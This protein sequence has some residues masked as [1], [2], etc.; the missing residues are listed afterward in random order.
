MQVAAALHVIT[1]HLHNG[2]PFDVLQD[3]LDALERAN[4]NARRAAGADQTLL[5]LKAA[6]PACDS[7][8]LVADCTS[9]D[10]NEW[11]I[12]CRN[13]LCE[14]KG[15]GCPCGSAVRYPGK[16]HRWAAGL[17]QWHDLAAKLGVTYPHL[18]AAATG[19]PGGP[20]GA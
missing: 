18:V 6:C 9:P 14:C 19:R 4:R 11:S 10:S 20:G 8:D 15:T 16:Q 13:R 3:L 7:R 1:T 12:R 17:G 5:V 2:T